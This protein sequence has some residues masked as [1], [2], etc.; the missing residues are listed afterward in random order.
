[1]SLSLFH[2]YC[3]TLI[4]IIHEIVLPLRFNLLE[5]DVGSCCTWDQVGKTSFE[6]FQCLLGGRRILRLLHKPLIQGPFRLSVARLLLL[7]DEI[8]P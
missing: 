7:V 8:L 6:V 1:M 4:L 2:I 5:L 3:S